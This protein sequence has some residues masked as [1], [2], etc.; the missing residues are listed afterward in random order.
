MKI[1]GLDGPLERRVA[2]LY[3]DDVQF[4]NAEPLEPVTVA[5][6]QPGM[7]FTKIL[8]TAMAGYADRPALGER[9][10]EVVVDPATGRCSLRLLPRFETTSY[11]ELWDRVG[12]VT[13]EWH[14]NSLRVGEFVCILG[15]TSCDFT[16]IDLACVRA[17]AIS[18]ALQSSAPA[19]QLKPIIAETEPRILASSIELLDTALDAA[20][21]STSL[22]RLLVFDYCG[23]IDDQREKLE[24]A[25]RRLTES[26]SPIVLDLLTDVI[27][28]GSLLPPAPDFE[29]T[30]DDDRLA[31]LL[32]TSGSTGTPK[33]AM[34]THK[35]IRTLWTEFWPYAR[36]LPIIGINYLPMTHAVGRALLMETLI[37]GGTGYFTAKSDL[38]TLLEDVALVRPTE[39]LLVPRVCDVLLQLYQSELHRRVRQDRAVAEAEAKAELRDRVLGGRIVRAA[40]ASAPLS[41]ET[42]EFVQSC[43]GVPLRDGYGSTETGRIMYDRR[44][45]RP[46]VLDYKLVDVPELGYFRTDTPYPRGE[47][48]VRSETLIP[49]YYKRP[50]LTAK[51]FDEDGYYRTG[52]IMAET[53]PNELLYVDR[54]N[55]VLKLAHGKF[56]A[57][58]RLEM[59]FAGSPLIQQI[60]IHC[61]SERSYPLAVVVA[62]P[63]AV[64]RAATT[65]EDLK[66]SISRSLR[67]IARDADLN[68]YESPRDFLVETT[69]FSTENRLLSELRKPLRP[70]LLAHYGARLERMYHE[71]AEQEA[72]EL[73][74]LRLA[75]RRGP[76][77]DTVV[78][79]AQALLGHPASPEGRFTELGGDS[80]SALVF[81][82]LLGETFG[83][84]V[85]VGVVINPANDFQRLA[86]HIESALESGAKPRTFT[87]VHGAGRSQARAS[88]LTLEKLIDAKTLTDAA[89]LPRPSG[90]AHTVLMTGATG[91]LGRFLCLEWLARM[92]VTGGKVLCL[93]RGGSADQAR[94]RLEDVFD[95]GDPELIRRFRRLAAD[96]LEVLAGDIA[97][98]ALGLDGP[99]WQRLADTVDMIVH[100]AALV[101]HVLPYDQLF[102]SN[103]VG[104]AELIRLA[105]TRRLKPF[106]YLST[107]AVVSSQS[108]TADEDADIR[109]SSPVRQLDQSYANGYTTSK[110]AGE[111]LLREAHEKC[112]LP[113]VTFRPSMILAH[114]RYAGQLNVPDMFTRLLISV[115]ATGTAPRSFY[116]SGGAHYDGLPV[117]FVAEAVATL[118]EQTAKGYQ[119]F[120]ALNPHDDGISLDVFV[121]W[122]I[123]ADCPIE[124]I[125]DYEKW[126]T[127]LETT[128]LAL[129]QKQGRRSLLPLLHVF[130]EPGEAVRGCGLP[131]DRFRAAVR[132]AGIGTDREIPNLSISL[133][134]K[135]VADLRL[136]NLI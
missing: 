105:I 113:V 125:D 86:N 88:D 12:A 48:L 5:Q 36:G 55:N 51:L 64:E 24:A 45:S 77:F 65:G 79:T 6:R 97:E 1:D 117:D 60:F 100:P 29:A 54:R 41:A 39:L 95:S 114:T 26:G 120:N 111:V 9:A 17:G 121:D 102:G 33:G 70:R 34:F 50:E 68:S 14:H 63:E 92:E 7:A 42:A 32:Y 91:Y 31:T 58:S 90:P 49:G 115:L 93:V 20:A 136:L 59:L 35:L 21:E 119:T 4:R 46:P 133:I 69:P 38:S 30:P 53:R 28:R 13:R 75:G 71:L 85:P 57:V 109:V 83:I 74:E 61:S 23:E 43:L 130:A 19:A 18:V 98:P 16:T 37:C 132:A 62:T 124:R 118:G 78:R 66:S 112:G 47:L 123:E 89:T 108:S 84:E 110:W 101:N 73:H 106:T 15:F 116:R 81:S 135:Y 8:A 25:R 126:L 99:T 82:R 10:T 134:R 107:F 129:P 131:A 104:T 52:D 72:R 76:V 127:R 96:R 27:E 128:I 44:I 67:Q 56:V 3:A 40:S 122:L 11:G 87:T 103:V 94:K 80:L 22:R 2:E